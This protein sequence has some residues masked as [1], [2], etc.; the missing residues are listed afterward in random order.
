M[1]NRECHFSD[2]VILDELFL[3]LLIGMG[4]LAKIDNERE[5]NSKMLVIS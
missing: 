4:R 1:T 2:R 3:D 5:L